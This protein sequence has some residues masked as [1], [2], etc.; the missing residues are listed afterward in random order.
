LCYIRP[1]PRRTGSL[2]RDDPS[3]FVPPPAFGPFR[4]LHQIGVGALGP[5][6]RTYEP[7]RDRLV[8][9]KVFRLDIT[10]EQALSLADELSRAADAGLFHPSIVEPI[11]AGVEGTVAYRAEEYVAAE[12]LDVAMRHYAPAPLEKALPFITQ[13]AGAIDFARAAGVGHGYLH[14]R[15]I[16]LTPEEACATGFGIV[17]ALERIGVRAPVRRPYSAPERIEGS[18]WGAPADVYSLGAIAYELLTGR[19]PAGAGPDIGS[20]DGANVGSHANT[21]LEALVTAMDPD[22]ARRYP[23]GLAFAASLESAARGERPA[24]SSASVAVAVAV[25]SVLAPPVSPEDDIS[26][27][28][29]EDEAH[30]ELTL[31]EREQAETAEALLPAGDEN[32]E[33]EAEADRLLMDAAAVASDGSSEQYRDEFQPQAAV[34]EDE[35]VGVVAP[36]ATTS[37]SASPGWAADRGR[38]LVPDADYRAAGAV[39]P[40]Q[41]SRVLPLAAM[42]SIGLLVG[43]GVGYGVGSREEPVQSNTTGATGPPQP[44]AAGKDFSEQV[45]TQPRPGSAQQAR[46][47]PPASTPT[48]VPSAATRDRA[49]AA[50]GAPAVTSGRLVVQSTPA[51][52]GVTLNNR[53]VG[54]TPLVMEK[55]PFGKY[56]VRVVQ[57]GYV[58]A[59]ED[60]AL[61]AE[62]TSRT[63]S[64]KLRPQSSRG[65]SAPVTQRVESTQRTAEA[66]QRRA[67]TFTGS[68]YIDSRPRGARVFLDNKQIGTTPLS[69]PDV[70]VGAHVVRLELPDHRTWSSSTRVTAGE[71]ARVTGSLDRVQ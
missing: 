69:I 18:K 28:R 44:A 71:Q 13:L 42:L 55:L 36:G 31:R 15:D 11:A 17:D 38:L 5:I 29:D 21:L 1:I 48:T 52:A 40:A 56:V 22:P 46:S 23:T 68:I 65:S 49:A 19:R 16:F 35:E 3:T 50:V 24:G 25:P 8:A 6:F 26:W 66:E 67:A 59:R 10:P 60:L 30:H 54:R 27:E 39:V 62:D 9:V 34:A 45:V 2:T 7:A 37:A 53:W 43:F 14:P 58:V 57:P 33:P 47:T 20:L 51:N 41:G 12:S 70:P 63:V 32:V 61:S 4:V 64:I